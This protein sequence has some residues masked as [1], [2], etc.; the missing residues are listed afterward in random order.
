MAGKGENIRYSEARVK[1]LKSSR[2]IHMQFFL[3]Y[4]LPDLNP[5]EMPLDIFS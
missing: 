2:Y 5:L 4:P 1:I 3:K